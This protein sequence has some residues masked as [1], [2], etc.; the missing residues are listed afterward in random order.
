MG[1]NQAVLYARTTPYIRNQGN[2]KWSA[3]QSV[4]EAARTRQHQNNNGSICS[5][6]RGFS[7]QSNQTV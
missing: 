7:A 1:K 3:T 4:A 6:N 2:R 5:R